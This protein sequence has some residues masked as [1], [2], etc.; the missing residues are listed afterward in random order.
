[1]PCVNRR[2]FEYLKKIYIDTA[3]GNWGLGREAKR[4]ETL[5]NNHVTRILRIFLPRSS[6]YKIR[7]NER[8]P[9]RMFV[10]EEG[11]QR[12][13]LRWESHKKIMEHMQNT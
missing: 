2:V 10:G 12:F 5:S 6:G 11:A 7:N 4:R 8:I 9:A 1:M 13:S 3:N